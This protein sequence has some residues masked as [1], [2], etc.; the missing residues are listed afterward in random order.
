MNLYSQKVAE[1]SIL[2]IIGFHEMTK[3]AFIAKLCIL[4]LCGTKYE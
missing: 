3:I 2:V 1:N 4:Q